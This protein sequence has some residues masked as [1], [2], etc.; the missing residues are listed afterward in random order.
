MDKSYSNHHFVF[1]NGLHRSGTSILYRV[2]SAQSNFSGFSGTGVPEDE[3][4]HLQTV[5]KAAKYY[6]GPGRFGFDKRSYLNEFSSLISDK[7]RQKLFDEW[8]QNWD[9]SKQFLVEK[10]PPNI[11]RTR[12]LQAMYPN[13]SFVTILRNPIAVSFATQKWSKTSLD[14]LF[15]HW[16]VCN[17]QY[18]DDSRMLQKSLLFKYEDF[19]SKPYEVLIQISELLGESLELQKEL[20]VKQGV[21]RK[22]MEIWKYYKNSFWTRRK[23]QKLILKYED[24][25]NTFG[26]SLR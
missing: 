20:E 19:T 12:F 14:S 4:Q 5:Y 16:L 21:N 7:N 8:S 24:S 18:K 10:S 23:A 9:L 15:K 11:I 25:F 3:G 26:Y 2:L 13:A 22:Y 6:G 17:Q 1:V